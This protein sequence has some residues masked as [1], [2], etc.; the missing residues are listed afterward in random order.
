MKHEVSFVVR[1]QEEIK[2]LIQPSWVVEKGTLPDR[3]MRSLI[4]AKNYLCLQ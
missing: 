3:E 2:E 1:Q 4:K